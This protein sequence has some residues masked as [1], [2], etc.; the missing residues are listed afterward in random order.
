M[1]GANVLRGSRVVFR[2]RVAT[3][4]F[5]QVRCSGS[6]VWV[7]FENGIGTNVE[8]YVGVRSGDGGRTWRVALGQNYDGVGARRDLGPE[9]GAWT[10][11][12]PRAAYFIGW[13]GPC[14]VSSG[15]WG[16]VVL[17][18]TKDGGRTFRRYPVPALAGFPPRRLRV[19][20][21]VVTIWGRQLTKPYAHKIVRLRVA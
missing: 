6:T 8:S 15:R 5:H 13:C 17:A 9:L 21:N 12:G 19:M 10:L 7:V 18:A 20:G 11:S 2:D 14:Q 1:R 16:T 4:M 3:P